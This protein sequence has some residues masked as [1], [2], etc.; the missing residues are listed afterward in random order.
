MV[1]TVMAALAQM[2]FDIKRERVADSVAKRRASGGDL[3]GRPPRFTASQIKTAAR[4]VDAD[5]P[6]AQVARDLGMSPSTLYRRI[7]GLRSASE[8]S[9]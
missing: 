3:G 8:R 9:E 2:E 4:L 1:F 6:A 5:V 7:A